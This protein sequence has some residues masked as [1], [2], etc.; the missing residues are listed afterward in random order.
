MTIC[1][2]DFEL[3][4]PRIDRVLTQYRESPK[5]LH[6]IRTYLRQLEQA[7]QAICDLPN[8]FDIEAAIGDQLTLIGKR[9]GWPRCHCVCDVQPV[10][11][12]ECEGVP[13]EYP[14]AG[15]CDDTVTWVD[16]G[17]FGIGDICINDDELYRKFLKVRRYQMMALFDI[18]NLNK[19]VQ[20][21]WGEQAMVLDAGHGR[22]VVAPGRDLTDV[23]IALLQLYPRV[24]PVT[25]G[26]E[27]RFH[28]G[29]LPVF[30]FGEGWGGFCEPW[31]PDGLTIATDNGDLLTTEN[32][33]EITTGPLTR[34][35]VWMCEFDVNPY[36]CF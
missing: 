6:L 32:D 15:F 8:Y 18:E 33:V 19:A 34:D 12:F 20:T 17:E 29:A 26:I 3:V 13:E 35:A 1:P 36:G 14:I 9:M 24:L 23:E 27:I 25:P 28:F 2:A 7:E 10:F 22:V 5:L 31:E 16:C 4:E 11:G 21:F 30:G